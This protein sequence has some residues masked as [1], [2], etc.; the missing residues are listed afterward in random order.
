MLDRLVF[1]RYTTSEGA[2]HPDLDEGC[3]QL[4]S[5]CAPAYWL[6]SAPREQNVTTRRQILCPFQAPSVMGRMRKFSRQPPNLAGPLEGSVPIQDHIR[7]ARTLID[8]GRLAYAGHDPAV[9]CPKGGGH[10]GVA[11][12]YRSWCTW[13][14]WHDPD[15]SRTPGNGRND[16]PQNA[17]RRLAG[18]HSGSVTLLRIAGVNDRF[19]PAGGVVLVYRRHAQVQFCAEHSLGEGSGNRARGG[20]L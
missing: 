15:D 14:T 11:I 2:R 8:H 20:Y 4:L 6:L 13:P 1:R 16:L 10:I 7:P 9:E 5:V 3:V 12:P 19:Y 17:A 18:T